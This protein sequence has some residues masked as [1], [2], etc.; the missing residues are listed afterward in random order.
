[1]NYA[2]CVKSYLEK[3]PFP[4]AQKEVF[5]AAGSTPWESMP[6]DPYKISNAQFEYGKNYIMQNWR[7]YSFLHLR[8]MINFYLSPESRR[9]CTLLGIEKY[10][11]PDGFLTTSS[12]KDKVVS[13]FRYKPVP[14]IAIGMY[15][16][17]LSGF[18]YFFTIIGFIKLAQQREWFIIALFLLT[19][20]Y[21]TFL[22]GPL[23]EGRQRVPIVPVYTAIAS[24]GLLK[25][26]GDRG[27]RFALNPSAR[28]TSAGRP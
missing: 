17:A 12:F 15:I 13:Y 7:T 24:Y 1:L 5:H 4:E 25:A 26:F 28:Q 3:K 18:V 16:F 11:F 19:M 2:A 22:P 6:S 23:G 14:E 27:I 21:F 10:G 9:I 20:L 8:G